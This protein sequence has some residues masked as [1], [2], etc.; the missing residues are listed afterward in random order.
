MASDVLPEAVAPVTTTSN[1][2]GVVV[3][4]AWADMLFC[5]NK[6]RNVYYYLHCLLPRR[7]VEEFVAAV[8]IQTTGKNVGAGQTFE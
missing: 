6:A 2:L 4:L 3:T 1:G 7:D 5:G 8:E